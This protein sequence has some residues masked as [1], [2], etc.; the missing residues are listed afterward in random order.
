MANPMVDLYEKQRQS[1]WLDFI[2]RNMLHDGGLKRYIEQDGIRGV[3]AN[4]TIF[5][6]AIGAGDDYDAQIADLVRRGVAPGGHVRADRHR[7][8]P[9]R[10]R[11]P[12]PGV[13]RIGRRRRL[14]EHR[15]LA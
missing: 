10:R 4:P 14:R 9:R 15:S 6:Q 11:S 8:H 13:R 2:R 5:A 1:P 3:T 7:G 12:A